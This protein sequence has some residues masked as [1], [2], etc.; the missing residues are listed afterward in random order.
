MT[1]HEC[2]KRGVFESVFQTLSVVKMWKTRTKVARGFWDR[3]SL[4]FWLGRATEQAL[5][6]R[7]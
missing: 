4:P 2:L 5:L 3:E 7:G 6:P 1:D